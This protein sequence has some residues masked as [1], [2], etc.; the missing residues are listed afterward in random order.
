M[1]LQDSRRVSAIVALS[2]AFAATVYTRQ[3]QAPEPPQFRS[4]VRLVPLDVRVLDAR[5]RPITDLSREDFTIVEE[6]VPQQIQHFS[7]QSLA[8]AAPDSFGEP[9][10]RRETQAV[11][12]G[13]QSHRVF[14]I[15]L[16][17]G[18]LTGPSN[19]IDGV[20]HLVQNRLLPQ[21]RVAIMAWNRATDFTTSHADALAVLTRFKARYRKIERA[22]YD[23]F[24]SPAY[25]YGDRQIPAYLQRDIDEVFQ[26]GRAGMRTVNAQLAGSVQMEQDLREKYDLFNAPESDVFSAARLNQLGLTLEEFFSETSQTMQDLQN[27]YAGIEFLRHIEGE[28][29]LVWLTEFGVQLER[30]EYDRDLARTAA[31]GR[32]VLN[33]IRTGGTVTSGSFTADQ[34]GSAPFNGMAGLRTLQP[35]ATSRTFAQLTGGRSDANR[36][37]NASVAADYIDQASRFQYLLGY[38]PTNADWNGR[39]RDVTVTVNRPGATVL[40]RRGYYARDEVGPIDRRSVVTFSRISGAAGDVR[41]IPDLGLTA[42]ASNSPDGRSVTL[43]GT[44]DLSRVNFKNT[45]GRM[46]AQVE[47]AAFC[48]DQRDQTVGEHRQTLELNY[49]QDRLAEVRRVGAP[50]TLTIPVRARAEVVKLVGYVYADDLTGSR[51]IDVTAAASR[52]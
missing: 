13:P 35:A 39:F 28:K 15:V 49:T 12:L 45:N 34:R 18:D 31:D 37:P 27:L 40:V 20:I 51:N 29:Q 1:R 50:F 16:G 47:V 30:F 41:E 26:S 7:V 2:V 25:F 8:A 19:G 5:G 36:F 46:V 17:R 32:V 22:L 33:V 21:D 9:L 3:S 4:G 42:T 52:R 11:A 48:Q 38:Y 14:L 44:V 24:R 43:T 23:F 10:R 6:R